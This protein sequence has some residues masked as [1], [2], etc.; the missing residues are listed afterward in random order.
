MTSVVYLHG[1][2]EQSLKGSFGDQLGNAL[3]P[4]LSVSRVIEPS[5][6]DLLRSSPQAVR[7]I[8]HRTRVEPDQAPEHR[9]KYFRQLA[10]LEKL[11]P[12]ESRQLLT[13]APGGALAAGYLPDVKQY[14]GSE[15]CRVAIRNRLI[16]EL[17]NER[18]VVILAHSLGSI[19]ALDFMNHLPDK[20]HV[21]RL[22]TLGSPLGLPLFKALEG[23]REL[24]KKFPFG[25]IDAW[26]NIIG[27]TDLVGIGGLSGSTHP[28]A[29]DLVV[30]LPPAAHGT[31][32][33]M[34]SDLVRSV[35]Q[36]ALVKPR[37]A[38][39][40]ASAAID[41]R[42]SAAEL[43]VMFA[44]KFNSMTQIELKGDDKFR[45]DV[46][47]SDVEAQVREKLVAKRRQD[48]K[49]VPQDLTHPGSSA[50]RTAFVGASGDSEGVRAEQLM[51]VVTC[52]TS[53]LI[54]PYEIDTGDASLRVV[55]R[56]WSELG[57]SEQHGKEIADSIRSARSAVAP[58]ET[59]KRVSLIGA[60]IVVMAI[61]G[62][63]IAL[64]GGALAGA[65]ALT[66]ALAAFGPGGMV[67]GLVL[68]GTL[69]STGGMAAA[70]GVLARET[71]LAEFQTEVIRQMTLAHAKRK[72]GLR[73]PE[74]G[75]VDLR[76]WQALAATEEEV[77][78]D[79]AHHR[80]VS[81]NDS[82]TIKELRA[83][84]KAL[85]AGLR[86]MSKESLTP[87]ELES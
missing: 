33:Y 12:S 28:E 49:T 22:V 64:G 5:Y 1:V 32:Q 11:V 2:G 43:Q 46:A 24:G 61:P 29:L 30:K 56:I 58:S 52:A 66:T 69:V 36:D 40:S 73:S 57:R 13:F 84:S 4:S 6:I 3:G 7:P 20:L 15:D 45:Y 9:S 53:N 79:L 23:A 35:L 44:L 86:W 85:R 42:L 83:K 62:I 47:R 80:G 39:P 37:A 87:S 10:R 14:L 25:R 38:P 60:G 17:K 71:S 27:S 72:I 31:H 16:S 41:A 8:K 48:H 63:G 34:K 67:G 26:L 65:A 19:I 55:P 77:E 76:H 82:P 21:S 68:S 51:A 78:R 70:A 81:D 74:G 59:W 18:E 50:W 75:R 54:A